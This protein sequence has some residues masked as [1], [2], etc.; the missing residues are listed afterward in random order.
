MTDQMF[1]HHAFWRMEHK[2]YVANHQAVCFF[3]RLFDSPVIPPFPEF[4]QAA[5]RRRCFMGFPCCGLVS[6][7]QGSVTA[8]LTFPLE[9][10]PNEAK[11]HVSYASTTWDSGCNTSEKQRIKRSSTKTQAAS[12]ELEDVVR[13]LFLLRFS[14]IFDW[15]KMQTGLLAKGN[16]NDESYIDL[17]YKSRYFWAALSSS[18]SWKMSNG[19]TSINHSCKYIALFFSYTY[20]HIYLF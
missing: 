5:L 13:M 19:S 16:P 14:S 9:W 6:M 8:D 18:L 2:T 10:S 4:V 1:F 20:I 11:R 12:T 15:C 17:P 3:Y 7:L